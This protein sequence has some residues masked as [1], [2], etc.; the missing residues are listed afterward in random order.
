MGPEKEKEEE[1]KLELFFCQL[2][3]FHNPVPSAPVFVPA[4]LP[5]RYA[6]DFV[7]A[8]P[9]TA[10]PANSGVFHTLPVTPVTDGFSVISSTNFI[11]TSV[12]TS[13]SC[14]GTTQ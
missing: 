1:D 6:I 14:I 5:P 9:V 12:F 8:A 13:S 7:P 10:S 2:H 11:P 4:E 3:E